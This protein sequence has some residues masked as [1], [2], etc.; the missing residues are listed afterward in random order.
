[1]LVGT[2]YNVLEAFALGA[3][4]WVGGTGNL[5]PRQCVELYEAAC[6]RKDFNEA[7]ALYYELSDLMD[8]IESS[9]F[10]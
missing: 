6:V 2:D 1:M 3:R 10:I 4:G 9:S 8:V 5:L 7:R